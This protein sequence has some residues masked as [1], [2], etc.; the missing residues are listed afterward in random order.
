MSQPVP[1]LSDAPWDSSSNTTTTPVTVSDE[2]LIIPN[3]GKTIHYQ[4]T[5]FG[6][7]WSDEHVPLLGYRDADRRRRGAVDS[8]RGA[9]GHGDASPVFGCAQG[10]DDPR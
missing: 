8:A 2:L 4:E 1:S 6:H 9:S 10:V 3:S 5:L 7:G